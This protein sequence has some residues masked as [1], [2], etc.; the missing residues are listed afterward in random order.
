MLRLLVV[1]L[2]MFVPLSASA[3]FLSG[4]KLYERCLSGDVFIRGYVAGAIDKS[5]ADLPNLMILFLH[6]YDKNK[7]A[8]HT[9]HLEEAVRRVQGCVPKEANLGQ[10]VDVFCKYLKEKPAERHRGG[11]ALLDEAINGAWKCD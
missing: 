5:Y 3:E 6:F 9:A 7:H 10:I 2:T 4:N 1:V 11:A 8:E